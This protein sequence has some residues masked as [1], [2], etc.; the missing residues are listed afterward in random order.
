MFTLSN[1]IDVDYQREEQFLRKKFRSG[2][3]NAFMKTSDF[4][5]SVKHCWMAHT[6]M[7]RIKFSMA[8]SG[9][10]VNLLYQK[11]GLTADPFFD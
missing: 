6:S 5:G 11:Y 10:P 4:C 7:T 3:S 1:L 8:C 9:A 2:S